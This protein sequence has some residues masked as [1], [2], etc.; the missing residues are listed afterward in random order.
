MTTLIFGASYI[1][2]EERA[3]LTRQWCHVTATLNP[4]CHIMAVHTQHHAYSF[5]DHPRVDVVEFRSNAGHLPGFAR[6]FATGLS[7]GWIGGFDRIAH[8]ECDLLLMRPVDPIFDAMP[9]YA[10]AP[11][12]KPYKQPECGLM[13][14][15]PPSMEWVIK[16]TGS[17]FNWR[18][19]MPTWQ[20]LRGYLPEPNLRHAL[21]ADLTILDLH[22]ARCEGDFPPE[23]A[24]SYDWLT[25]ASRDHYM[26][27]MR[28]HGME[29]VP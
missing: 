3:W 6:S 25:H 28:G 11:L 15:R 7:L 1:A 16:T 24:T 23:E 27:I 4:D 10:A 13:F 17:I 20:A 9:T 29:P 8:V 12:A 19:A 22:G 2:N 14:F 21:G 5:P 18:W 26:A